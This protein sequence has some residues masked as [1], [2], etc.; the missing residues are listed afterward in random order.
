MED[1]GWYVNMYWSSRPDA[2]TCMIL[3]HE[4]GHAVV[5]AAGYETGPGDLDYIG[6]ITEEVHSYLATSLGSSLTL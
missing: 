3:M 2:G 4:D 6:G 1:D 5:V